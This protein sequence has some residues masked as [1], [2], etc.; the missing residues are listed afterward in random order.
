VKRVHTMPFGAQV[1]EGG[2][3]R[4]RLWAPARPSVDLLI[5]RPDGCE[6]LSMAEV[7]E[8]WFERVVEDA[9]PGCRYR[10][11]ADDG[12]PVP[13]PAS[14]FQPE[15]V[16]GASEVVDPGAFDWP[17]TGWRGRPWHEVVLYE[18]HVGTFDGRGDYAGV[19]RRLDHLASLGVTALELMPL[20]ECPGGRSWGYD[21]VLPFAPTHRH[22]G[23]DDLKRLVSAAHRRGLMVFLDVVYNHFGPEGNHLARYAPAFFTDRHRTPWGAAID[24]E[25]TASQPVRDFFQQN[26]LFWLEEYAFDGLR[27][28]A[29][30][31][32]HDDSRP[33]FL[34][35]LACLV[36][37]QLDS[38]RIVHLVL[39]NDA[40]EARRLVRD[41]SGRA[42]S[43]TA[44]W[45]DDLHHALH[46]LVTGERDGYY[47]D[48]GERPSLCLGRA[49][50]EGFAWQGEPSA[51]RAGRARGEPSGHLPPDAFVTFLQN[52]DQIGNRAFGE[53][54]DALAPP[55]AVEAAVAVLLL[56]P[57]IPLVFMGEEWAASE[58]FLYFCDF[59]PPL[60]EQVREGRRREFARFE[61][62]RDASA[63]ER[64]PD[65]G[66][67]ATW[68]AC[69]LDW[70]RRDRAP[71]AG[72]L[73]LFRR[74]LAVRR[75]EITPRL[76]HT[77]RHAGSFRTVGP[78]VVAVDWRLGDGSQLM[79]RA[80]LAAAPGEGAP[81]SGIAGR[82]ERTPLP[83]WSVCWTLAEEPSQTGVGR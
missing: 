13:D 74:L 46:V 58:P 1:L 9:A 81:D 29:V 7:D 44:Q 34:E 28:D 23:P 32:I 57:S 70:S 36:R 27:L 10:F 15:G 68:R 12:P 26:A 17:D 20:A 40:N 56:A 64:I 66:A 5:E 37:A 18:I 50:A 41:A 83:P 2:G 79:L 73:A 3:I 42:P 30:H 72:R 51:Y 53:R 38:R 45:N 52:H 55:E 6:R 4:F 62:F 43:F 22:G 69:V 63:R 48:F 78:A 31:A 33:D 35:E 24:F 14:R 82:R 77:P 11:A 61:R 25:G 21:G 16:G 47:A 49:L 39:E 59:D 8:G 67:P 60:A 71:H 19:E 76:P 54:L 80:Q 65:P 75:D